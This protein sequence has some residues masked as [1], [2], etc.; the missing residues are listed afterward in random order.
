VNDFVMKVFK[1]AEVSEEYE[2]LQPFV[3]KASQVTGGLAVPLR[4]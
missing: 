4:F 3:V 2:K 1:D